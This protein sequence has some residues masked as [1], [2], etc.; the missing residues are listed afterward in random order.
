[1]RCVLQQSV[2]V[3]HYAAFAEVAW[4]ES[5]PE[6]K[7]LCRQAQQTGRRVSAALVERLLPGVTPAAAARVV[8]WCADLGLCDAQGALTLRGDEAAET[9]L[10]PIP[11]QGVYDF[12]VVDH[13]LLG[14]R[15][16]HADRLSPR[17]DGR[18]DGMVPLR[19]TPET[20]AVRPSAIDPARRFAVR[21][22]HRAD[23][24]AQGVP[25]PTQARCEIRWTLDFD[26]RQEQWTLDGALDG[27]GRDR[28]VI[29]HEPERAGV[30]LDA[31]A[32][33]W[34]RGPLAAHGQW[35]VANRRLALGFQGLTV[36]EQ[37]SFR[38]T[39]T[40]SQVAVPGR[41]EWSKVTLE[42]VPIG[43]ANQKDATQWA[44]ARLDRRLRTEPRYRA[45]GEVR[46]LFAELAEATPLEPL[47]PQLPSHEAM[48]QA[49]ANEPAVFWSLAAPVDL[50]PSGAAVGPLEAMRIGQPSGRGGRDGGVVTVPYRGGWSMQQLVE[51]LLADTRPRRGLLCD[52]Y[53]RGAAKLE[54]LELLFRALRKV[55]PD[56]ALE[57]WTEADAAGLRAI[58]AITGTAARAYR[59]V[60]PAAP[61]DRY[62]L[63]GQTGSAP[64][65][66]QMSN[67]PLD[68]RFDGS[69]SPSPDLAL[70]WRDLTA[71]ALGPDQLPPA[72]GAWLKES[73]R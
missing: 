17:C 29:R 33:G 54:T 52:R 13:P 38:R 63:L 62:L 41:G 64:F 60:F 2:A 42:E 44:C 61:H 19:T 31:L 68:A 15:A 3:E 55:V 22:K 46:G 20:G 70:R 57:V 35:Q 58:G 21:V 5:R 32:E 53:V 16:L 1:M 66:W 37:E 40:L 43:P 71:V 30:D 18:F 27:D 72:L 49:Y 28:R 36:T 11:E 26:A 73:S 59:E 39:L 7:E 65:G 10:V 8:A 67:S 24:P 9:G 45:R 12:W 51:A 69:A 6:L 4:S 56:F 47:Q 14:R 25:R 34:G 50:A 23:A 48:L